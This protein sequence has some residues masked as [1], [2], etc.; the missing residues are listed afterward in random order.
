MKK[1][2]SLF[3]Y[4]CVFIFCGLNHAKAQNKAQDLPQNLELTTPKM[5]FVETVYDFGKVRQGEKIVTS[6]YFKNTG[7]KPLQILQVQASCGCTASQWK[8]EPIQ[9][10]EVS[11]I[12]VTFDTAYKGD[13]IGK[14]SKYLLIISNSVEKEQKLVMQGEVSK[15]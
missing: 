14:Q 3:I 11:E 15:Q 13:L 6:F 2:I 10:N 12:T 4:T 9:P 8:K 7:T 5:T 1:S